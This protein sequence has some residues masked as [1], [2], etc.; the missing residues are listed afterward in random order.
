MVNFTIFAPSN[1]AYNA[2][3][4]QL[5]VTH[6]ALLA[7]KYLL[8]YVVNSYVNWGYPRTTS[9][10]M[11]VLT[12]EEAELAKYDMKEQ[13]KVQFN[14]LSGSK[15]R[16]TKNEENA[17][18]Y[19]L[20]IDKGPI[21]PSPQQTKIPFDPIKKDLIAANG[22]VHIVNRSLLPN[23]KA[24][25]EQV[26][27]LDKPTIMDVIKANPSIS[28]Y[29][30]ALSALKQYDAKLEYSLT[31]SLESV[32]NNFLT[33]N[34]P[35]VNSVFAPNN[36]AF[37]AGLQ[38][39]GVTKAV[40]LANERLLRYFLGSHVTQGEPKTMKRIKED[41]IAREKMSKASQKWLLEAHGI[42]VPDKKAVTSI[43]FSGISINIERGTDNNLR[44]TVGKDG[45]EITFV[46]TDL[47]A[48][49]GFL[50]V[51]NK[52]LVYASDTI[53]G[54]LI[55]DERFS[56]HVEALLASE[57]FNELTNEM[58]ASTTFVPTNE[59]YQAFF[60]ERDIDKER[61]IAK[62]IWKRI[63]VRRRAQLSFDRFQQI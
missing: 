62:K 56:I 23:P 46:Q 19:S 35:S 13:A 34:Y 61:F 36:E 4:N 15:F 26:T 44:F 37:K 16:V 28:L 63:K 45:E 52:P 57:S 24:V 43:L 12:K 40:L 54:K 59:A 22:T 17:L 48:S 51:I 2:S 10:L 3:L 38:K 27:K 25:I 1:D 5:G 60:A 11:A 8:T 53:F 9:D 39:L 55:K 20:I 32:P 31:R 30:E 42:Q 58:F 49:N 50:H 21:I 47:E 29:A 33:A 14:S 18:E 6:E 41:F 7:N